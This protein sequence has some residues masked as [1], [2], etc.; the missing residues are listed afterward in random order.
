MSPLDIATKLLLFIAENLDSERDIN[1]LSQS[2]EAIDIQATDEGFQQ[3]QLANNIERMVSLCGD[4]VVWD[5]EESVVQFAHHSVKTFLHSKSNT[6]ANDWFYFHRK[7]I[8]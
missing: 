6:R 7:L 3:D 2:R 5:D 8:T 4:L 1:A